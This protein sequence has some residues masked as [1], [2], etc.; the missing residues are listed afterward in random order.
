MLVTLVSVSMAVP[1]AIWL[2]RD[3]FLR[4]REPLLAFKHLGE[5]VCIAHLMPYRIWHVQ[6][7]YKSFLVQWCAHSASIWQSGTASKRTA[8]QSLHSS[9][10]T[11]QCDTWLPQGRVS[12]AKS[13]P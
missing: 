3:A 2:R 5:A 10:T 11:L 6:R 1:L 8:G 4:H 13:V 7:D 9:W 12:S